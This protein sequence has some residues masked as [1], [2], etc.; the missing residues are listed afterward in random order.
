MRDFEIVRAVN[1]SD[2]LSRIAN[3]EARILAGGTTLID[4]MKLGV[5]TPAT[6]IDISRLGF[7]DIALEQ[8]VIRIGA[9]TS[10]TAAASSAIVKKTAPAISQAILSGASGQIRNVATMAGNLLQRTRCPYFR[11]T[12]W[13]CNKRV[14]GS[15]CSAISGINSDHAVLGVSDGCIAVNPSD[16]A[17]ALVAADARVRLISSVGERVVSVA[18]LYQEPGDTPH[19][20]TTLKTGELITEI[21]V[22]I[23]SLNLVGRYLKLR[24]RASYEF[25]RASVA[26]SVVFVDNRIS[27]VA[28]AIGGLG[29]KPWRNRSAEYELIGH[30][31]N[32][33]AISR[34]CDALLA[35]AV[36]RPSNEYKL[37]LVRGAMERILM[38]FVSCRT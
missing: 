7:S 6:V 32:L 30:P 13:P 19:I 9:L 2:V 23:T 35:E 10:N 12:D 36:C 16:L 14:P 3:S 20:E 34:Y 5:E 21:L 38:G 28:I 26:A 1:V 17:V 8:D 33:S 25:A 18:S 11:S 27:D 15:G 22:P 37:P 31:L 24:G 29:V 4:L